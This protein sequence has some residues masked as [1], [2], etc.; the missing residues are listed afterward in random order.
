MP[1]DC[2]P[3]AVEAVDVGLTF[4]KDGPEATHAA[5]PAVLDGLEASGLVASHAAHSYQLGRIEG[6]DAGA[7]R[8]ATAVARLNELGHTDLPMALTTWTPAFTGKNAP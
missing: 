7:E 4:L 1:F 8:C 2:A 6:G 3:A 5:M